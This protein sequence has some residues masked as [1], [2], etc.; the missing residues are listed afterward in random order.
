MINGNIYQLQYNQTPM[1]SFNDIG[2]AVGV[3]LHVTQKISHTQRL[4]CIKC[5]TKGIVS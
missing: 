1:S 3:L 2:Q 5:C 4:G